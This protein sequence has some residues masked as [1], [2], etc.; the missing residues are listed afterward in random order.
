MSWGNTRLHH[1][2]EKSGERTQALK[3]FWQYRLNTKNFVPQKTIQYLHY[4]R[5]LISAKH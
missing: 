1:K 2:L 4:N 5:N 3:D